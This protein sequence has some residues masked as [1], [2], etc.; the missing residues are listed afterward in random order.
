[1]CG[2]SRQLSRDAFFVIIV[3]QNYGI[4]D[5]LLCWFCSGTERL[6]GFQNS[7]LLLV[8]LLNLSLLNVLWSQLWPYPFKLCNFSRANS[9]YFIKTKSKYSNSEYFDHI[10]YFV[11]RDIL[12]RALN[13]WKFIELKTCRLVL[14]LRFI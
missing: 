6:K 13:K 8:N 9:M 2:L 5:V 4:L 7:P 14:S 11:K 1:M 10:F 3:I 12:L